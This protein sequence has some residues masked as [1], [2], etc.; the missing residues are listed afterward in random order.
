MA[1]SKGGILRELKAVFDAA[2]QE[3]VLTAEERQQL[4]MEMAE[5]MRVH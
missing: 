1:A 4:W 2:G 3:K 5:K